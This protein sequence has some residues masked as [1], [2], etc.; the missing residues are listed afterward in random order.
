MEFLQDG[1][2]AVDLKKG[3]RGGAVGMGWEAETETQT[4]RQ[5]GG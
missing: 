3:L 4:H 2:E 1:A 5:G